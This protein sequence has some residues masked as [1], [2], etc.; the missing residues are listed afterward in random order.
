MSRAV[1]HLADP[2]LPVTVEAETTQ[3]TYLLAI[4]A[5]VSIGGQVIY[6]RSWNTPLTADGFAA[7]AE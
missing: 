2:N 3:T 1:A 5:R 6:D 7:S 4:T